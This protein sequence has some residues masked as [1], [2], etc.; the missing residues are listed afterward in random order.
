MTE[1]SSK[2]EMI[3]EA[4]MDEFIA[5]GWSG[6]RMQSIAD[7]AGINKTLL[8]YYFRSKE[9]L[10]ERIVYRTMNR[11]FSSILVKVKEKD[12]FEEFLRTFIDTL[13]DVT[14]ANPRLP[15]FIM[16]ELSRGGKSVI[17]ILSEVLAKSDPPVTRVI[18]QTINRA[19]VEGK[20]R[21]INPIQLVLTLLGS[22]LYFSMAE[23]IVMKIGAMNGFMDG[24]DKKAFLE[25]R[26]KEIFTV[27]YKGLR[28]GEEE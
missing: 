25:E 26:K 5:Q 18:L 9:N 11:L 6:A 2:E 14:A 4:A 8:H 22:C 17:N 15:M 12:D 20:I 21:D 16:Q 27:L 24:F 13:I 23:P 7:R 1:N 10:Y 28:K 19:V 3:L